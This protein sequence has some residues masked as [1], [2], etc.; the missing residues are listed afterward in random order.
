MLAAAFL[1]FV[2]I[3]AMLAVVDWRRGWYLAI[4]IGLVQD[5]IRKLTPGSPVV[6]TFTVMIVFAAIVL[7]SHRQ[8]YASMAD[9]SRR[10]ND[11]SSRAVV[12]LLFIVLAA[13]TGLFTF[14]IENWKVPL[15]SLFIYIAPVPAVL[16]GYVYLHREEEL[17]RFLT[18]FAVVTSIWMIGPALEYYRINVPG[19]GMVGFYGDYIRFMPGVHI[20]MVSGFYR[21]PD[22]MGWHAA[23][24][25]STG[26]AMAARSGLT[27][28][29]WMWFAVTGWGFFNCMI[30]GRRKAVYFVVVFALVF[31]WRYFRRLQKAQ[32]WAL[33]FLAVVMLLVVRNLA[34]A[35]D[36]SVYTRGSVTSRLEIAQR[37]EGGLIETV[38]QFGIMGAGLGSATQ[39]VRHLLNTAFDA[40]WQE[41]GLGKLAVELG[42]PGLIAIAVLG[43]AMLQTFMTLTRIGDVP[44]SSQFIRA[45]LFAF[46]AANGVNFMASA[47]AYTDPV[48]ALIT[49]FLVGCL[50]GTA[51]LDER[52][53][54]EAAEK[55]AAALTTARATA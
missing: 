35:E 17:T 16:F 5:P 49:A 37:L 9:F 53:A 52:F 14:G 11:I 36:T 15:L 13:L 4:L 45:T 7:A 46:V 19:L 6:L 10:F 2:L 33:G 31:A 50:F 41:G 12:V 40:G 1:A 44:G 23:M 18:F 25:A 42:V 39:G 29:A 21:A 55:Q 51:T 30:S 28:R 34:S 54:A 48:L 32:L 38:R 3:A 26:I 22:I 47:Q 24:L 27:G 8:L 20:R 43:W